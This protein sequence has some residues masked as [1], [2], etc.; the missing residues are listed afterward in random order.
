MKFI[1]DKNI[2][3]DLHKTGSKLNYEILINL[4]YH[5]KN[6]EFEIDKNIKD[7]IEKKLKFKSGEVEDI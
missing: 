7:F 5:L 2:I 1:R 6:D 3:K 4:Y